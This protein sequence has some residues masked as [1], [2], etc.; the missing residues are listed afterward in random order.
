[1]PC[2]NKTEFNQKKNLSVTKLDFNLRKKLWKCYIWSSFIQCVGPGSSVGI[3]TSYG[4]EGPGDRI[5]VAGEIF[6]TCPDWLWGP[7]SLLY[8]GYWVYARRG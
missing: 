3:V 4:L 6:R 2:K 7:T 5:P 1:M 8:S